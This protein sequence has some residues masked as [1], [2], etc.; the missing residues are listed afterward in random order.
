[1]ARSI[2]KEIAEL[3]HFRT[4]DLSKT[5]I[6]EVV[7]N[8]DPLKIGRCRVR[9]FS[10]F[11][12][13]EI[14]DIP[15][16]FPFYSDKFASTESGGFGSFSYPKIGTL[17]TVQFDNGD[18]YSP[19]Y[20]TVEKINPEMQAEIAEDYVNAQ[21]VTYD[22]DEDLKIL[23][24]QGNGLLLWHKES[25]FR[26][27]PAT[28]LIHYHSSGSNTRTMKGDE[29]LE[30]VAAHFSVACPK[31]HLGDDK[32]TTYSAVKWEPLMQLLKKLA[33]MLDSKT[34]TTPGAAQGVVAAFEQQIKSDIV[35]IER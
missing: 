18:I 29:T 30:D 23:Y 11:D 12:D 31:I 2:K 21:V 24:T 4:D 10:K 35:K 6:G 7:N 19:Q 17:V 22:V 13:L 14:E 5:F 1:M 32:T 33:T 8:E 16:A 26:I 15:W 9:V 34:P 20:R 3:E 28:D 25:F 27:D